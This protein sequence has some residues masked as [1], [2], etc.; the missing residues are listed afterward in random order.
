[1]F[2]K[3]TE[4]ENLIIQTYMNF[5]W[6]HEMHCLE[7]VKTEEYKQLNFSDKFTQNT[8]GERGVINQGTIP[9]ALYSMLVIPKET[10]FNEYMDSYDHINTYIANKLKPKIKTNYKSDKITVDYLRHLRNSV[11]HVRFDMTSENDFVIFNDENRFG[12]EFECKLSNSDLGEII[13]QLSLVH[14]AYIQKIQ[15][16]LKSKPIII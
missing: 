10:I 12:E 16:R 9:V 1:M 15:I 8:I 13:Q 7:F 14:Q 11:S 2:V 4:H 3:Y 5:I 6:L